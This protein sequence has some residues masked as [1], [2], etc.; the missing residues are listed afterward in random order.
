MYFIHYIKTYSSTNKKGRELN[1][2]I[3]KFEDTL[4]YDELALD[5]LKQEIENKVTELNLKYPNVQEF[6]PHFSKDQLYV[7]AKNSTDTYVFFISFSKVRS[8][9]KFL[10]QVGQ[11]NRYNLIK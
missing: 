6:I 2:F 10:E 9:Y 1:E 8:T 5:T 3:S 7:K 4:I 11:L